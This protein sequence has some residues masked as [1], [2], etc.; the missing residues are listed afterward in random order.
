M[1]ESTFK[2]LFELTIHSL[3]LRVGSVVK[4]VQEMKTGLQYTQKYVLNWKMLTKNLDKISK[5]LASHSKKMKYLEN[6]SR[7]NNIRVN[8]IPESDSET[9]EDAEVK[10]KR[11]IKDNLVL[12]V[13]IER[14]DRVER[15]EN[16][17]G[18]SKPES[19]K[20]SESRFCAKLGGRSQPIFISA[21][22]YRGQPYRRE[23]LEFQNLKLLNSG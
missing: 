6:Q 18:A 19:A 17:V 21:K 2:S 4:D 16:Q 12:E 14:A 5:D 23:S 8:G 13:D 10:I 3:T 9:W 20:N 1:Q 11:A 7:R 22:I 15:P